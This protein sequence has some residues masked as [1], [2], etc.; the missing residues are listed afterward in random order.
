MTFLKKALR[1]PLWALEAL[2]F[3]LLMA[4]F[5]VIGVDAASSLGGWLARKLAP[6]SPAHKT[7]RRNMRRALAHFSTQ[8][9]ETTLDAMWDNLGRTFAEYPHFRRFTGP[10]NPRIQ[11]EGIEH[12]HAALA[13]G[14]GAIA[15]S[16]HFANWELMALGA[17][18]AGFDGCEIYRIVNNPF[19]NF[20]IVRQRRRHAYPLQVPKSRDGTRDLIRTLKDGKVIAML[21]DQKYREGLPIPFFNRDAMTATGPAVLSLRTGAA[22]APVTMVRLKGARFR[23]T[24]HPEIT[25]ERTGDKNADVTEI[26]TRINRFLED[27]VRAQP[28]QWLWAHNRWWD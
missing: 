10:N 11:I 13:R 24:F 14:Q 28:A 5:R 9:I 12:A 3:F 8:E 19:V 7:A 22:I 17:Y 1:W 20:W 25:Y 26:L 15:T 4:I 6:L 2:P 27:A 16:G 23:L 18:N 21:A